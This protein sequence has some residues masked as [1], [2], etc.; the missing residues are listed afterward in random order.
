[1]SRKI[2]IT[3]LL[4]VIIYPLCSTNSYAAHYPFEFNFT[5]LAIDYPK[6]IINLN[7]TSV[8]IDLSNYK[9]YTLYNNGT[10]YWFTVSDTEPYIYS[11]MGEWYRIYEFT[12]DGNSALFYYEYGNSNK[13]K[14]WQHNRNYIGSSSPTTISKGWN[15]LYT[16]HW[17]YSNYDIKHNGVVFH[18]AYKNPESPL[19]QSVRS[20]DSM[21]SVTDE[22]VSILPVVIVV[23]VSLVA[24]RKGILF[25]K[26][27][28]NKS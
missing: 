18:E 4:I 10:T 27:N 15:P 17:V 13:S 25:I 28:L 24:I 23:M 5:D 8:T 19:V 26:K 12:V 1:M 2:L 16:S 3:L 9:Y 22:I 6:E 11:Y 7:I 21:N 14:G 20:V